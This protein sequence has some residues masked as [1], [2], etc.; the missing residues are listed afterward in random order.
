MKKFLIAFLL[1]FPLVVKSEEKVNIYV[2]YGKECPHCEALFDYL[3]TLEEESI[4]IQTYEVW[5]NK[6]N[7]RLMQRVKKV[8]QNTETGVP[9]Y[10]IGEKNFTGYG[11][12]DNQEIKHAILEAK[13]DPYDVMDHLP[14]D[15][16]F[17]ASI[18][19]TVVIFLIC[20]FF[21]IRKNFSQ[22][23]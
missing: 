12:E 10:V 14:L 5:H 15:I 7:Q 1:F 19:I 9:Y 13:Q 3:D 4:S 21:W 18:G 20:L 11:T 8:F 23:A 17:I 6:K 22:K 16:P 2:F